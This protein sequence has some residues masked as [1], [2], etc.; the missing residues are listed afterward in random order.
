MTAEYLNGG[1]VHYEPDPE[2]WNA[3][4]YT[5]PTEPHGRTAYRVLGWEVAPDADTEWSGI[6]ERTGM[7]VIVMY[8]DDYRHRVDPEDLEPLGDLEYCAECGQIGRRHDG[9]DRDD[10]DDEEDTWSDAAERQA[11][12]ITQRLNDTNGRG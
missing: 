12:E 3:R 8:G 6:E 4:A 11:E 9:R 2:T 7:V 5:V 10:E 1:R